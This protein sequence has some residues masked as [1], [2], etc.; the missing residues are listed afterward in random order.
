MPA[1]K[2][3]WKKAVWKNVLMFFFT[4]WVHNL[5]SFQAIELWQL[6]Q[7][8]VLTSVDDPLI[9]KLLWSLPSIYLMFPSHLPW[10]KYYTRFQIFQT[11]MFWFHL[12]GLVFDSRF[13][14]PLQSFVD[15]K[16]GK[17]FSSSKFLQLT[18]IWPLT[19]AFS[20]CYLAWF[21]SSRVKKKC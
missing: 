11:A 14:S 13:S 20:L 15:V 17:N 12:V 3:H 18:Q 2:T 4:W 1:P 8:W 19:P 9:N 7:S 5:W 10:Y 21:F 16:L 6:C